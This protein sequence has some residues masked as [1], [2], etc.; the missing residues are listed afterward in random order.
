M[1][2]LEFKSKEEATKFVVDSYSNFY[3]NNNDK[4]GFSER[5]FASEINIPQSSLNTLRNNTQKELHPNMATKILKAIGLIDAIEPV[6]MALMPEY[7]KEIKYKSTVPSKEIYSHVEKKEYEDLSKL[8]FSKVYGLIISNVFACGEETTTTIEEI[9]SIVPNARE[10]LDELVQMDILEISNGLVTPS[11]KI[12]TLLGGRKIYMELDDSVDHTIYL[13]SQM[14]QDQIKKN[15]LPG[16]C[17]SILG[18]FHDK[19]IPKVIAIREKAMKEI[20]ELSEARP[21]GSNKLAVID[22]VVPLNACPKSKKERTDKLDQKNDLD[23]IDP[24]K[25]TRQ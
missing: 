7:C 2:D 20:L 18:S 4:N 17:K 14:N 11:Q 3:R 1:S 25:E 9:E 24:N 22:V 12:K 13:L 10:L 16:G 21:G 5:K 15:K 23:N 19:D 8:Y 6:V